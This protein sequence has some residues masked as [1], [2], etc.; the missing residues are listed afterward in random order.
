MEHQVLAHTVDTAQLIALS[1]LDGLGEGSPRSREAT[2]LPQFMLTPPAH[3]AHCQPNVYFARALLLT[4]AAL[5][6]F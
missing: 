3:T 5:G 4:S 6:L 1:P 2:L